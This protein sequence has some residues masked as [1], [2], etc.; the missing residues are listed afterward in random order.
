MVTERQRQMIQELQEK[1]VQGK[2]AWTRAQADPPAFLTCLPSGLNFLIVDVGSS[3][4]LIS[5]ASGDKWALTMSDAS[6]APLLRLTTRGLDEGDPLD[7]L[8]S[9]L[10]E[11]ARNAADEV[12]QAEETALNDLKAL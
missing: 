8:L 6:G 9:D 3:R 4:G 1:T 10:F 12:R 7:R 2:L 11:A 5:S